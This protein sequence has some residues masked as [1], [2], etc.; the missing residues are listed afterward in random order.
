MFKN[1]LFRRLWS[2]LRRPGA[3]W[4]IFLCKVVGAIEFSN[5][6]R[7]FC[8]VK[9]RKKWRAYLYRFDLEV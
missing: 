6:A 4:K 3:N 9:I 2:Q 1:S 7:D 5:L 8:R